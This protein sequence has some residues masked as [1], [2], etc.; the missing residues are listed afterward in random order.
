MGLYCIYCRNILKHIM[1]LD[2]VNGDNIPLLRQNVDNHWLFELQILLTKSLKQ[3][4]NET[5]C[6]AKWITAY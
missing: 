4:I 6:I 3:Y 1:C 5:Y 2:K